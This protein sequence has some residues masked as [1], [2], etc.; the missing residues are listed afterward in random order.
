MSLSNARSELRTLLDEKISSYKFTLID[1]HLKTER[2]SVAIE[3]KLRGVVRTI[4]A[5]NTSISEVAKS[6]ITDYDSLKEGGDETIKVQ[7]V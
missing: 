7:L 3:V 4:H 6:L 2:Y 5:C 1:Y